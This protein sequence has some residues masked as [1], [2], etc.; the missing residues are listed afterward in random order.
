MRPP[1]VALVLL[2]VVAL[3][4]FV[5]I[6]ARRTA[7]AVRE[8]AT[9]TA[10]ANTSRRVSS[11]AGAESEAN[12]SDTEVEPLVSHPGLVAPVPNAEAVRR[13]IALGAGGTYLG[14]ILRQQDSLLIRWP[15]RRRQ[16]V[17]V[18]IE[19]KSAVAGFHREFVDFA[20][21][22]FAEWAAAET[23]VP[24]VFVT[25]SMG[26]EA[27]VLWVQR[28]ADGERIG[29]T[30]QVRDTHGWIVA[31]TVRIATETPDGRPLD[32]TYVQ[33]T[34][35][36]EVGHLLGLNHSDDTTDIMA[37]ASHVTRIS[38]VDLATLRLLYTLPA[39]SLKSD[40]HLAAEPRD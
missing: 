3:A 6:E 38:G 14:A 30:L 32:D 4:G 16:P 33:A 18:W 36:H 10:T 20:R 7:V 2:P 26:S 8:A 9:A 25:D 21:Q 24:Y 12:A 11:A 40:T 29:S 23:P 37:P 19:P 15:D 13:R 28:F 5:S 17:R 27:R 22:A 35:I 31:G 1:A 39:G 34:A